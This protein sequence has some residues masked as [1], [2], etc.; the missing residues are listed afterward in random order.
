[1]ENDRWRWPRR[2]LAD[3]KLTQ[4]IMVGFP[5][6]QEKA[7]SPLGLYVHV[8]F[9]AT[10]CDFCAFYQ[11]VPKGDAVLRYLEGVEA[12]AALVAWLPG[13]E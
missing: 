3:R 9:C 13:A 10:T 12:E 5:S 1:M 8:P 6:E 11:T 4:L 2:P 7:Q